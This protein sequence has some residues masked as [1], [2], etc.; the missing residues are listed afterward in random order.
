MVKI[1]FNQT[2][3]SELL[4]SLIVFSHKFNWNG[5]SGSEVV[6]EAVAFWNAFDDALQVIWDA[7]FA[8]CTC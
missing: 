2:A 3:C 8:L 6:N 7:G 1:C 4:S 5:I